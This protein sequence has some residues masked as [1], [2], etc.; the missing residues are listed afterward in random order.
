MRARLDRPRETV[1]RACAVPPRYFHW[2]DLAAWPKCANKPDVA[3]AAWNGSP[4]CVLI[5]GKWGCGKST[6]AAELLY[7]FLRP[8]RFKEGGRFISAAEIP[9]VAFERR[10]RDE[11]DRWEHFNRVDCLVIDDLGRGYKGDARMAVGRLIAH[12]Y[13]Y[14]LPTIVTSNLDKES[15][16]G[17]EALIDRLKEG[18]TVRLVGGSRR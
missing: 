16:I 15:D 10:E 13:D 3:L 14:M 1:L 6:L 17:D 9:A 18:L 8:L 11:M 12:R 4:W 2:Q 7:R 5:A